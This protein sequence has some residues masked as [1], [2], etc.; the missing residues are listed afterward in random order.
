MASAIAPSLRNTYDLAATIPNLAVDAAFVAALPDLNPTQRAVVLEKVL[1]R[2]HL[3]GLCAL[4]AGFGS[5]DEHLR[6]LIIER[7]E[8]LFE[9]ARVSIGSSSQAARLS[10]IELIRTSRNCRMSYLLSESFGRRCVKTTN[11]ATSALLELA[12]DVVQRR[13]KVSTPAARRALR[14][15]TEHLAGS[16]SRALDSWPAHHRTDVLIAAMCLSDVMEE[17]L[18]QKASRIR[19]HLARAMDGVLLGAP[20][21]ALATFALRA[22]RHPDLRSAAAHRIAT[23]ADPAF[24]EHL[25]DQM[26][27]TADRDNARSCSRIRDL[28]WLQ[29]GASWLQSLSRRRGIAAVRLVGLSGI[30]PDAK[31]RF[32]GQMIHG[33]SALLREAGVWQVVEMHTPESVQV[34][35]RAAASDDDTV[36][37]IAV[38]E[39]FRRDPYAPVNRSQEGFRPTPESI[40]KA[41]EIDFDTYWDRF[42]ELD[43]KQRLRAGRKLRAGEPDR[44]AQ[45][46]R[47]E[48]ASTQPQHRLR[49]LSIVRLLD[50][51]QVFEE[52]I[53]ALSHDSDDKTRSLAMT[54]LADLE[55]ATACR[56][57]R[58][59]LHDP[60][61]RVQANAVEVLASINLDKWG[62]ELGRKLDA[63]HHRVRANAVRALLGQRVREAAVALIAMLTEASPAHRISALW[64]VEQLRLTTLLP[65]VRQ[66][67]AEDPDEVVRAR[68]E[69]I[70]SDPGMA[71]AGVEAD[72]SGG[73]ALS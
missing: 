16:L 20:D 64:V 50:L 58:Q 10:A 23:T 34:L 4:V 29:G 66:M 33:P 56:I 5:F 36:S 43:D 7:I 48:L 24:V 26:W 40:A 15:D 70:L 68:A 30:A 72:A 49:A 18:L 46:V 9:A 17:D 45:Y 47:V 71:R 37:R 27:I 25:L 52:R 12:R 41:V 63:D 38:Q 32:F 6:G 54:I 8:L 42:D 44:F 57:L 67:A 53:Y 3:T 21:A 59:A 22:L 55:G 13:A 1:D 60:N 65:R 14:V 69:R 31:A 61:Q 35:R 2:G 19:L 51:A 73:E 11:A 28:P 39:L 62:A